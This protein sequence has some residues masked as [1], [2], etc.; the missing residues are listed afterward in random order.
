[1]NA[2]RK[3]VMADMKPYLEFGQ[4]KDLVAITVG[5]DYFTYD[6]EADKE[7]EADFGE[8]IVAVEKDWLFAVM[9]AEEI[10]EPLDYLQ[11][12]YTWDDSFAWFENAKMAGKVVVVEF[13]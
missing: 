9:L 4:H 11:N 2:V 13:N 8:V 6:G 12:E 5:A 1:M 3:R 7:L 10:E